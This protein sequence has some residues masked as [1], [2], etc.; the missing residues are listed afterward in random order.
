M[1]FPDEV[2]E[3]Q[4]GQVAKQN[5]IS[6]PCWS[7]IKDLQV[8]ID[9]T[10]PHWPHFLNI[11]QIFAGESSEV[12]RHF[13]TSRSLLSKFDVL[14]IC[15]SW[16]LSLMTS[17]GQKWCNLT[18]TRIVLSSHRTISIQFYISI[19][20]RKTYSITAHS[21]LETSVWFSTFPVRGVII[22]LL[23]NLNCKGANAFTNFVEEISVN[24]YI[25][26]MP[27]FVLYFHANR[28]EFSESPRLDSQDKLFLQPTSSWLHSL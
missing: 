11:V 10:Y 27:S 23:R 13:D 6:N 17:S 21:P 15:V 1:N 8:Q 2:T 18:C 19:L 5:Q 25:S 26:E 16:A 7:H 28:P 3:A 9:Y 14:I 22:E 4:K 20:R 24:V 12:T